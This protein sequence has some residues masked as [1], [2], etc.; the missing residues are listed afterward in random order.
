[1]LPESH[2]TKLRKGFRKTKG[3]GAKKGVGRRNYLG[4]V[5]NKSKKL[6]TFF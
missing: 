2:G 5:E 1:V 6:G 3:W 4:K